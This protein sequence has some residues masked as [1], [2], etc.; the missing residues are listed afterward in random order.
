MTADHPKP[1]SSR[2]D[3]VTLAATRE[4]SSVTAPVAVSKD[5]PASHASTASMAYSGRTAMRASKAIASDAD[6]SISA[7][8]AAHESRNAPATMPS[9]KTAAAAT[10]STS[11]PEKRS[12]APGTPSNNR[13]TMVVHRRGALGFSSTLQLR[14]RTGVPRR[15]RSTC[16]RAKCS[17]A[18]PSGSTDATRGPPSA[19]PRRACPVLDTGRD[20][21]K[22]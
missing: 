17:V 1:I 16:G 10:G 4:V 6:T 19:F 15:D 2:F 18:A 20:L 9:P 3:P 7:T 11:M 21:M 13:T 5:D 12:T 22:P 8:S 14:S